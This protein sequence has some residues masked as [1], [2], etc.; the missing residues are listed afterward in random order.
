MR[1]C[2][3]AF[4]SQLQIL[5]SALVRYQYCDSNL[6]GLSNLQHA[7]VTHHF[8]IRY[9][10]VASKMF[11]LLLRKHLGYVCTQIRS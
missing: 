10:R 11:R 9:S 2:Q 7:T 3:A 6:L 8:H 5:R 4:A 1:F